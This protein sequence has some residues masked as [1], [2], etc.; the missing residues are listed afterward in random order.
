MLANNAGHTR[1]IPL[2]F[3][4]FPLIVGWELTLRCNLRCAHCGSSAG[5]SR[6]QELTLREAENICDQFPDLLVQEVTFTGGEPLLSAYWYELA[7]RIH[8]LDI[9]VKI[10]SN[11][12]ALSRDIVSQMQDVGLR[13]I[14][15][16]LDGLAATHD[17]LRGKDGLF[18]CLL[19]KMDMIQAVGLPLTVI[20]TVH[21][22]NIQ[23]LPQILEILASKGIQFWQ[24][25]PIFHLG[26]AADNERLQ[27]SNS[28]FLEL[29]DFVSQW[30]NH[31]LAKGLK[32]LPSD[33]YGYFTFRDT[34]EPAWN[35]C[36]AGILSCG[37]TSDGKVK[38][39]LSLPNHLIEGDL[40][41]DTLW[42]I[43]FKPD[44][45]S[46]TRHFSNADLGPNCISCDLAEQCLGGCS[47]MSFGCTN[48]FHNNPF[49]FYRIDNTARTRGEEAHPKGAVH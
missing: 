38:G 48:R 30:S 27:L 46:Y 31:A 40:R 13:G 42:D 17:R 47:A 32:I 45:F 41:I 7:N 24:I 39:C 44:A 43:W 36:P 18:N 8:K 29:G 9:D 11:G 6:L 5:Y 20:T 28:Q 33:S 21:A 49:C 10:L 26:R 22:Q 1:D 37:I 19:E 23:E 14:G 15:I 25:Q 12:I 3:E 2:S 35:G 16:S 34:R 4:C